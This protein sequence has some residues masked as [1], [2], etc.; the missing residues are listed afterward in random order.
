MAFNPL[1]PEWPKQA[2]DLVDRVVQFVRR[3]VTTRAVKITNGVVFG[4][5]AAFAGLVALV[6]SLIISMRSLQAYLE[7]NPGT[8]GAWIVGI[9]AL[10][11]VVLLLVGLVRSKKLLMLVAG[12]LVAI[13]GARW[14]IHAGDA[15]IDHN[16]AVWIADL[17]IGGIFVIAGTFLM[18]KRHAPEEG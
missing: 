4:L 13:T 3:N 10:V 8:L 6:L 1:N 9:S 11:G 12:A 5:L 17:V 16:T 2:A 7:W 18:T 15:S 14:A